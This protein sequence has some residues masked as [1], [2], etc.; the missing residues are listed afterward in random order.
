MFLFRH[1][2][3]VILLS[4]DLLVTRCCGSRCYVLISKEALPQQER[5]R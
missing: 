2:F 1:V 4:N 3:S 5:E